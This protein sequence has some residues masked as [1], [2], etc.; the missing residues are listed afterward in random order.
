MVYVQHTICPALQI[1]YK[2]KV[3]EAHRVNR[4]KH[5]D[6]VREVTGN[7]TTLPVWTAISKHLFNPLA[8]GMPDRALAC[9]VGH[10]GG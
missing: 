5:E 4:L 9:S 1:K 6:S 2:S 3:S 8:P 10:S 7:H